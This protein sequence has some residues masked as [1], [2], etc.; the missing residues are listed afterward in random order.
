MSII[1]TN[2]FS[3]R[4]IETGILENTF[5]GSNS[6]EASDMWELKTSNVKLIG[7][8]IYT[9]LVQAEDLISFSLEARRVAASEEFKGNTIAKALLFRSLGQR[10][11][12]NFYLKINKPAIKTKLF[13]NR[14]KAIDWLREEYTTQIQLIKYQSSDGFQKY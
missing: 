11:I 10:I 4:I 12:A 3:C 5:K 6:I 9:V 7:N 1:D 2:K 13:N 8:S 14:E